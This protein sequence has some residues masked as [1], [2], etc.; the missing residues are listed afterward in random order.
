MVDFELY[1]TIY[2]IMDVSRLDRAPRQDPQEETHLINDVDNFADEAAGEDEA[3][4]PLSQTRHPSKLLSKPF[5]PLLLI[6][7]ALLAG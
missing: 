5:R 3:L 7:P 1:Q 4:P 6:G 2:F